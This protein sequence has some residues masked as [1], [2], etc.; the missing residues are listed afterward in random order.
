MADKVR[1]CLQIIILQPIALKP[2]LKRQFIQAHLN[3]SHTKQTRETAS[4][5]AFVSLLYNFPNTSKN[6]SE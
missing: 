6:V 3:T 4:K 5:Y 1:K 2:L